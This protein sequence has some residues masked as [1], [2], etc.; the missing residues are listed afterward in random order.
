MEV[1]N[2]FTLVEILIVVVILG[3]LAA[4]T[5]P[6]FSDTGTQ[7][8]DANIASNLRSVRSAI[9]LYKTQHRDTMP[10]SAGLSFENSLLKPTNAAGEEVP[11][12]SVGAK[13]PYLDRIPENPFNNLS[14]IAIDG[15][16]G[17]NTDGW[18][19]NS[20]T[21]A[22]KADDSVDHAAL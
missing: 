21:G 13:G 7:A 1:K 19:F 10:G 18:N 12:G 11:A 6:L 17:D 5:L 20:S 15:T 8:R 22:F 3:I 2:G 14:T 9:Q 16:A 4:V